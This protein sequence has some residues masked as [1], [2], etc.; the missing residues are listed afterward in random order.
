MIVMVKKILLYDI[1]G[2]LIRYGSGF[3]ELHNTSFIHGFQA[4]YGVKAAPYDTSGKTDMQIIKETL[5]KTGLD[6]ERIDEGMAMMFSS[7]I[8]YFADGLS[9]G[10]H[11]ANVIQTAVEVLDYLNKSPENIQGLVTGNVREI[12]RMKLETL[13][14][15]HYFKVGGFGDSSDVRSR[16]V[17]LAINEALDKSLVKKID[18]DHVYVIG[19]TGRD[20]TCAKES[21]V[22]SIAVATGPFSKAELERHLPNYA[23]HNLLELAPILRQR[24]V[25]TRRKLRT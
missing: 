3:T 24:E 10:D 13:G 18:N 15:W 2:T 25:A 19:D 21:G 23:L 22:V 4:V 11:K 14:I 20:I 9:K 7:M 5:R 6:E 17:D 12:A 1:D 16:L 8:E